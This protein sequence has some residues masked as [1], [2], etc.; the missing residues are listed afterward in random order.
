[1]TTRIRYAG[2]SHS[3]NS[4]SNEGILALCDRGGGHV[5]VFRSRKQGQLLLTEHRDAWETPQDFFAISQRL[6]E[7]FLPQ[8]SLQEVLHIDGIVGE[9]FSNALEAAALFDGAFGPVPTVPHMIMFRVYDELNVPDKPAC[10][11]ACRDNSGYHIIIAYDRTNAIQYFAQCSYLLPLHYEKDCF[12]R[13][14]T[15]RLPEKSERSPLHICTVA[16]ALIATSIEKK[17][18]LYHSIQKYQA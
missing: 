7:S 6:E 5:F 3:E 17:A 9:E 1:M 16:A 4:N 14:T 18:A 2:I 12:N 13:L 15:S 8:D 11:F 10:V